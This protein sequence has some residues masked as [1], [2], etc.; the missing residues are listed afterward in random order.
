MNTKTPYQS[1]DFNGPTVEIT[2]Q[3]KDTLVAMVASQSARIAELEG[4]LSEIVNGPGSRSNAL[5]DRARALLAGG[6]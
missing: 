5:W 2:V 3:H 6:R 1:R 4:V